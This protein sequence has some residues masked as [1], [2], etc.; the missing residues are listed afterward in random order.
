MS[1]INSSSGATYSNTS[2]IYHFQSLYEFEYYVLGVGT[3]VLCGFG[4]IGNI[5][6]LIV[7][8]Q[9]DMVST[10][11]SYLVAL[12]VS[13]ITVLVTATLA[14]CLRTMSDGGKMEVNN[15]ISKKSFNN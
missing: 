4:M 1:L 5:L 7:L 13:D 14:V 6:A 15:V 9:R 8:M 12:A 3:V 11:Y 2:S 10:T